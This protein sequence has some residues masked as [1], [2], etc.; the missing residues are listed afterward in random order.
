MSTYYLDIYQDKQLA[1]VIDNEKRVF[2]ET[3]KKGKWR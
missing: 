1:W 3:E 2:Q